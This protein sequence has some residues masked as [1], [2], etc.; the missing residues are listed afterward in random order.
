MNTTVDPCTDFYQYACG[1]WNAGHPLPADRSRFGRFNELQDHN[2][3]ISLD[4]LQGAAA[5]QDRAGLEQ[6]IGD[7]YASCM[8]TDAIA[9]KGLEPLKPE[10]DRIAAMKDMSGIAAEMARLQ[11]IGVGVLFAFGAQPDPRD[12]NRTIAGLR[13]GRTV[14]ARPR[15][16]SQNRCEVPRNSPALPAAHEKHVPTGRR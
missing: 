6:T 16:L 1:T 12:S 8:N 3:R 9:K 11:R 13:P 7:F 4:I 2:E 5:K 14:A 15:L 10:L